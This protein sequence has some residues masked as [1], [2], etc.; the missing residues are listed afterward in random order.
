MGKLVI[1]QEL[2]N[3]ISNSLRIKQSDIDSGANKPIIRKV[4]P[5]KKDSP[6]RQPTPTYSPIKKKGSSRQQSPKNSPI[7]KRYEYYE[8]PKQPAPRDSPIKNTPITH[9]KKSNQSKK[10][11]KVN[12][13]KITK[14]VFISSIIG[15][16][17]IT[18][19][20][21]LGTILFL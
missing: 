19:G 11:D 21:K 15:G 7:K 6:Q 4:E 3:K 5:P 16:I 18:L 1:S 2:S 9:P 20:I 17:G 14:V 8:Y 13:M 12:Y 10:Q